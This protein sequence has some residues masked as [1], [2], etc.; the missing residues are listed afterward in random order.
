MCIFQ[1]LETLKKN[2]KHTHDPAI[3]FAMNQKARELEQQIEKIKNLTVNIY[4][5]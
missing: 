5:N 3:L 1:Q 4:N 2:I